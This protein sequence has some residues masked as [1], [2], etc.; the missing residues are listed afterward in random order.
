MKS[1][2]ENTL[3]DRWPRAVATALLLVGA[4][5]CYQPMVLQSVQG[6]SHV[7]PDIIQGKPTLLAFLNADDRKCDKEIYPLVALHSREASPVQVLAVM[8]YDQ[9]AFV[10]DVKTLEQAVFPVLLDPDHR[11]VERHD[12]SSYPT[13]IFLDVEGDEL[14]RSLDV[15]E[16]RPWV[17]SPRWIELALGLKRGAYT[18]IRG[19]QA[20]APAPAGK[21]VP[22]SG[23]W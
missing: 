1:R 5:G 9:Y 6:R 23:T 16:A 20:S 14:D 13:Y 7:Y 11:L 18:Q 4:S 12:V 10:Q 15:R 3:S 19:V 21:P 22:A 17:D 2:L 8:V